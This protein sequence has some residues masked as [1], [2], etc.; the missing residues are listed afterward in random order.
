MARPRKQENLKLPEYVY[1]SGGR[2]VY[3]PPGC[4]KDTRLCS[5]G[6]SVQ[7][8]WNAYNNVVGVERGHTLAKLRDLFMASPDWKKLKPA[9]QGAYEAHLNAICETL[10]SGR[11]FGD[12]PYA[13]VTRGAVQLYM[14]FR[15]ATPILANRHHSALGAAF[16]WAARRDMVA[17]NPCSGVKRYPQPPRTRYVTDCEYQIAYHL[18][19]EWPRLQVAMEFAYLCRLRE[20]EIVKLTRHD[21]RQDGLLAERVKGSKTQIIGSTERLQDAIRAAKALNKAASIKWLVP[22]SDGGKL[23]PSGLRTQWQRF[24]KWCRETHGYRIEWTFH[25]LKGKGVSDFDGSKKLAGGHR[26]ESA[27]AVYDRRLEVVPATR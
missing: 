6:A 23:T 19:E 4:A 15:A 5:R 24:R 26:T 22:A 25:D 27:A 12:V 1:F 9:T 2:W 13:S 7:Q 16:A 3:R 20:I 11:K 8:I 10:V 17:V 14:D 18:A 21:D